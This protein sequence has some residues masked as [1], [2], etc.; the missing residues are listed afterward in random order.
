MRKLFFTTIC[1]ILILPVF[2]C[3]QSFGV[4][5]NTPKNIV[6]QPAKTIQADSIY[7][8]EIKHHSSELSVIYSLYFEGKIAMDGLPLSLWKG[9]EYDPNK[10]YTRQE[11]KARI[12]QLLTQ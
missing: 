4:K 3:A 9:S 11:V 5:L 10:D 1:A 8:Q 2:C 7:I 6:T 12:K